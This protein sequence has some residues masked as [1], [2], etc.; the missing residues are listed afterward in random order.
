MKTVARVSWIHEADSVRMRL[1]SHGLEAFIPDEGMVTANPILGNAVGGIRIQVRDEDYEQAREI[2]GS[3]TDA[4]ESSD[5]SCPS[6]GSSDVRYEKIS[7]RMFFG[8]LLL[9]GFPF[10]WMKRTY[11]CNACGNTWK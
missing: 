8:G 6:C 9:L 10:L 2:L 11:T 4:T 3:T 1:N 7:R 5:F